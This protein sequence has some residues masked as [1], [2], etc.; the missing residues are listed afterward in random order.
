MRISDLENRSAIGTVIVL[1]ALVTEM[2][3]AY[4]KSL[5]ADQRQAATDRITA[6]ATANGK[7]LVDMAPK[8]K[9][10]KKANAEFIQSAALRQMA[11]TIS[12]AKAM[13]GAATK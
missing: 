7:N 5:P 11:A 12:E 1:Q 13:I 6:D 8:D 4:L 3:A 10:E 2:F 9:P